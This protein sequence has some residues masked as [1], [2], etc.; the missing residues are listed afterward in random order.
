[1]LRLLAIVGG[2]AVL[3]TAQQIQPQAGGRVLQPP[4]PQLCKESE[5]HNLYYSH[6][7]YR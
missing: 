7:E 5:S 2:L 6:T 3:A 1:M 4:N